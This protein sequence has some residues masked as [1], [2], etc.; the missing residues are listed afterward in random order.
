[1]K[2]INTFFTDDGVEKNKVGR[3]KLADEE[4]KRKSL[5]IAGISFVAVILL[6]VFGYGTLF[7]FKG[8]NLSGNIFSANNGENVLISELRP[9]IKDITIKEGT[10]RKVYVSISPANATNKKIEYRSS[11]S[12][13]ASVDETGKVIG[14]SEGQTL[15]T[16]STTDGSDIDTTFKVTVIKDASGK[17]AFDYL[18]EGEGGLSY[19]IS[20]DNAKIK[21][22]QYKVGE[23]NFKK[24]ASK[25][26]SGLIEFSDEQLKEDITLKVIYN[27][28]NSKVSKYSVKTFK[29]KDISEENKKGKCDLKLYDEKINSV[30]YDI[31]CENATVSSISYK[32]GNGSYV[33]IDKSNLAN[34]ILFEEAT[35]TRPLYFNVEYIIDETSVKKNISESMVIPKKE[36]LESG[37]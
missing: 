16:A 6:L 12:S 29:Y 2:K 5:I 15:I 17:C 3:P 20:C 33:E 25:K 8:L 14:L 9:L 10:A 4:T 34:I 27:S 7:G 23:D 24:I 18:K 31:T 22:I 1:M 28:N 21:E 36:N 30:R 35:M 19:S 32:I 11:D 13:V 37:E 26:S